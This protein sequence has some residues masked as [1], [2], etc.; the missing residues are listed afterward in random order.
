MMVTVDEAKTK[1][2]PQTLIQ[3]RPMKCIGPECIAGQDE[4]PA[5]RN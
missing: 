1:I 4:C 3:N 2:C 5:P